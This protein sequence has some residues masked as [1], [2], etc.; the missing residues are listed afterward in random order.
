MNLDVIY[1]GITFQNEATTEH[2]DY[3]FSK[4]AHK[5]VSG[6]PT[7]NN[8]VLKGW[9]GVVELRESIPKRCVDSDLWSVVRMTRSNFI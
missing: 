2:D 6:F 9:R 5:I 3:F 7:L 4:V 1:R 8:N